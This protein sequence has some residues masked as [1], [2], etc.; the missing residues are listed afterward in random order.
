MRYSINP[1][2]IKTNREIRQ[3]VKDMGT[4]KIIA[5]SNAHVTT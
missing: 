4:P 2:E 5:I 1:E 3:T